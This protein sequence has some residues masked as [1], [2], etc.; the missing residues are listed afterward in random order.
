[1]A[2]GA[3]ITLGRVIY[4]N[5]R[6]HISVS[7]KLLTRKG[8]QHGALHMRSRGRSSRRCRSWGHRHD[9]CRGPWKMLGNPAIDN[10]RHQH[11]IRVG[12]Q[13]LHLL[14]LCNIFTPI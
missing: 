7:N 11:V 13:A 1:M 9:L 5:T 3:C 6:P 8:C 14:H 4:A 2:F 10:F 12:A